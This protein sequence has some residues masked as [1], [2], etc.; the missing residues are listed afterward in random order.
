MELVKKNKL[1]ENIKLYKFFIKEEKISPLS[2]PSY[3]K[4]IKLAQKMIRLIKANK[5]TPRIFDKLDDRDKWE[6]SRSMKGVMWCCKECK[7][8]QGKEKPTMMYMGERY[9]SRCD[10]MLTHRT[11]GGQNDSFNYSFK[12]ITK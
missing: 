8:E 11:N 7:E 6:V 2:V 5:L 4:S 10:G 1:E 9:C 3:Q 12:N